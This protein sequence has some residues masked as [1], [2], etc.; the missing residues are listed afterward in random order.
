MSCLINLYVLFI[1]NRNCSITNLSSPVYRSDS[2]QTSSSASS[3]YIPHEQYPPMD[4]HYHSSNSYR[5]RSRLNFNEN[6]SKRPIR[7]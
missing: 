4:Y 6:G 5:D 3:S 7:R 2:Y 1:E